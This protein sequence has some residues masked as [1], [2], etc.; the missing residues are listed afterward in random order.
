VVV[1]V[2]AFAG[3]AIAGKPAGAAATR[4]IGTPYCGE[5]ALSGGSWLGGYGV[6]VFSNGADAGS[7]NS[8]GGTSYV[9]GIVSGEEWQCVELVD[10]LYLTRGWIHATWFGNGADMFN[11]APAGLAKQRQGSISFLSPGDVVSYESP[12]GIEPGHV[13][14]VDTVTASIDGGWAVGFVNQNGYLRTTGT[15]LNGRLSMNDAWVKNFPVVGVVHHPGAGAPTRPPANMLLNGSFERDHTTGWS[16]LNS[17]GGTTQ[18]LAYRDPSAPEGGNMLE[19]GSAKVGASLYQD[20]NVG[21]SPNESYT[22]TVWARARTGKAGACVVL[23][24]LGASSEFGQTCATV[25]TSWVEVSAPYDVSAHGLDRLRAQVILE[26][27]GQ[28]LDITGTALVNDALLNA[29]FEK[30]H[31]SGWSSLNPPGGTTQ[32]LAQRVSDAP[33][34]GNMLEFGSV[35][36]GASFHQDISAALA[37]SQ[38][39][40]FSV[41]L[42]TR[43][44]TA[45]ACVALWG[46]GAG[47][48]VGQTCAK[49][50]STWVF[51]SAPYNVTRSGLN[52]L[53]AQVYLDSAN[54][55]LDMLGASLVNDGLSNASFENNH[56]AG[57][58]ALNPPGGGTT[59]ALAYH[60]TTAPEGSNM[61][62]FGSSRTGASFYQ[63]VSANL[64]LNQSYT[65]SVWVRARAGKAGVCVVLS[66]LGGSIEYGQTC[67]TVGQTWVKIGAPFDVA[68]YGL[69]RLRAQVIL[70]SAGQHLDIAGASLAGT[71]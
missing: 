68:A 43:S 1:V 63:D 61:L 51:V 12:G 40:T 34:G 46:L 55:H 52:R 25:G 26:T 41:W 60:V 18:A 19:F 21:L 54:Q 31:T 67:A 45:R 39:Y 6:D 10:R 53:R 4:L 8:C 42:R 33:E 37:P 69:D 57:W 20:V 14:I 24:G 50:G 70:E 49:V 65:F 30:D 11:T 59:Q 16:T 48:E 58:S 17:P 56:T 27:A 36:S 23:W 22:F 44:G 13:G 3:Y 32:A 5:V 38:S 9:N 64:G 71:R 35:K 2:V 15:L 28:H 29:S 47:S 62:E 66:G 7:G